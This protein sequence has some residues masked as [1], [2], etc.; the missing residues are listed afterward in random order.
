MLS[1]VRGS[2][3]QTKE[4][5]RSTRRAKSEPDRGGVKKFHVGILVHT[6][7][8][9]KLKGRQEAESKEPYEPL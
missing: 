7:R 3:L 9:I 6:W 1:E 2:L 5:V 8:E 4:A